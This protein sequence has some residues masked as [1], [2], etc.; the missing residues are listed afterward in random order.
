M[1][2]EIELF[3]DHP[4]LQ[5]DQTQVESMVQKAIKSIGSSFPEGDVSLAMLSDRRL[6]ELHAEYLNDPEVTDVITFPGDAEMEF[7]GEICVS[8]DRAESVASEQT[9]PFNEELTLYIV[10]GLLH[11]AG[12]GDKTPSETEVMRGAEKKVMSILMES[13]L[14]PG[15]R[16]N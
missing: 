16:L 15:F 9:S 3:V 1:P 10:H 11:L 6:A 8:V 2:R 14:I 5:W 13:N 12:L 4:Y 7:A